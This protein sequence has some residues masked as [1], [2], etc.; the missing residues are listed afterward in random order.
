MK[1]RVIHTDI[2][3]R[4][5]NAETRSPIYLDNVKNI[6]DSG[7]RWFVGEMIKKDDQR[8]VDFIKNKEI[9]K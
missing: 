6:N 9:K 7:F 1:K 3:N 2:M 4:L 8:R 5:E